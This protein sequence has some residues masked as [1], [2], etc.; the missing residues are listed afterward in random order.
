MKNGIAA[1]ILGLTAALW[2]N[3]AAEAA[4]QTVTKCGDVYGSVVLGADLVGT[5]GNCLTVMANGVT[6][7]GNGHRISAPGFAIAWIDRSDVTVENVV[8]S[9][10]IQIYGANANRNVVAN[11]TFGSVAIYM[12]DDNVVRDS[13]IG[14]LVVKGLYNQPPLRTVITGNTIEGP[15][16]KLIYFSPDGDGQV[17]CARSDSLIENNFIHSTFD[18]ATNTEDYVLLY[19]RCGTHNTIAD[20]TMVS[21]GRARGIY[22][23]DNADDN[24]IQGNSVWINQ[25]DRAAFHFS[26]GNIDKHAPRNNVIDHNVFRADAT[27]SIFIQSPGFQGNIFTRNLF[28]SNAAQGAW[29]AGGTANVFDHNTFFNGPSSGFLLVFQNVTAPGNSYTNNILAG[30]GWS[31]F[32][33]SGSFDVRGYH[34]DYNVFSWQGVQPYG[35]AALAS[36]RQQTGADAHS[37]AADPLFVDPSVGNFQLQA[38]SPALTTASDGGAAGAFG[39]G[40]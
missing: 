39:A 16:A 17:L 38:G 28:W 27:R 8:S 4:V 34:A 14:S 9:K 36:W 19:L 29:I 10:G 13:K 15:A 21:H 30:S 26:T 24:L 6:I 40:S 2:A 12:G 37:I 31:L 3:V 22:M 25:G 7:D 35:Q 33:F 5:Q 11:S 32:G 20:N 23:R 1:T 18:A